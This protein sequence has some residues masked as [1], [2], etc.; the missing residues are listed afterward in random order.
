MLRTISIDFNLFFD[1]LSGLKWAPEEFLGLMGI[2]LDDIGLLVLM[3]HRYV[4]LGFYDQQIA[5]F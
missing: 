1:L 2:C 5:C 4:N 3:N